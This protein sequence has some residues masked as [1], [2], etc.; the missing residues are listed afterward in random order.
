[1]LDRGVSVLEGVFESFLL[2]WESLDRGVF[3]YCCVENVCW[4][5]L[6]DFESFVLCRKFVVDSGEELGF[7][8]T[9]KFN[10]DGEL[11]IRRATSHL[12]PQQQMRGPW[13]LR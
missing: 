11:D 12:E 13:C 9:E 8:G 7:V 3:G 1:M 2:C 4:G 5:D 6:F 10:I